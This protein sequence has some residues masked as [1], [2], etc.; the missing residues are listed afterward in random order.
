MF[1]L[2]HQPVSISFFYTNPPIHQSTDR[3]MRTSGLII[4]ISPTAG[5]DGTSYLGKNFGRS[6]AL[7]SHETEPK[8]V[9]SFLA[10]GDQH[11]QEIIRNP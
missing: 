5:E 10:E 11:P 6:Q 4:G 7:S 1:D 8:S 2:K 9:A 3:P